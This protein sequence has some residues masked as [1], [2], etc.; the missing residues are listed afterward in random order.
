MTLNVAVVK[1]YPNV[2]FAFSGGKLHEAE[3]SADFP[4]YWKVEYSFDGNVWKTMEDRTATMHSMIWKANK[5][6]KGLVYP[7]SAEVGLGFTEHAFVF[8]EDIS[9]CQTIMVRICPAAKNL[10]T[11]AYKGSAS[12]ANRP[13]YSSACLV[14]FG[15]IMI[16]Y[17]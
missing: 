14:N 13:D 2:A 17:R 3:Y 9:G 7:L 16:R 4:S 12:R 10:S 1:S 5:P 8:P 11:Y 15:S 6:I